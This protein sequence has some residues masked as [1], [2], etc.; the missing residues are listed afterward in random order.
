MKTTASR[1][2]G[3][4]ASAC[5]NLSMFAAHRSGAAKRS[6][7][8]TNATV[9]IRI[10]GSDMTTEQTGITHQR[11]AGKSLRRFLRSGGF[12]TAEK[13]CVQRFDRAIESIWRLESAS[14]LVAGLCRGA[15]YSLNE[16]GYKPNR[17]RADATGGAT[18]A[19]ASPLI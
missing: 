6:G 1:G 14:P 9:G 5:V 13:K 15:K 4:V 16:R 17:A 10:R 11:N 2:G 12:P 7:A 19:A 3:F 8:S 18:T